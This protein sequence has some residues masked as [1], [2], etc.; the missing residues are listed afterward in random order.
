MIDR[1]FTDLYS[2]SS[3]VSVTQELIAV[4]IAL[5]CGLIISFS[6]MVKSK[7]SKN[8]V[9][10]LVLLPPTIQIVIML[11]N[12]NLGTAVAI[13]GAFSLV[14]FRSATGTAKEITSIFLAMAVGLATGIGYVWLA[15]IFTVAFCIILIALNMLPFG[16]K[17]VSANT[18]NIKVTIPE[19]L[20]Y[21]S[22][23][24]D[25][26]TAHLE[27]WHLDRV[28]TTNM[29]S[30]FELTYVAVFKD[31]ASQKKLIDDMRTRNGNL[32]IIISVPATPVKEEL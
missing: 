17:K 25:L 7:Y 14:R 3:T 24:D 29:G 30:M 22:I 15:L 28:K 19:S 10:T 8:F 12:G 1:I 11:I 26:F 9:I 6:Y 23:Y 13:A 16:E 20:D 5:L 2:S 4:S 21:S 32:P 27:S 18:R 31:P